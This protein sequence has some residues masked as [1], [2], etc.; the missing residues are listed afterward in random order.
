ME[1][2]LGIVS[3][4]MKMLCV[5]IA[6]IT[7]LIVIF[8]ESLVIR[9][10]IVKEWRGMGISKALGMTSGQLIAEIMMSNAPTIIVGMLIGTAVSRVAGEKLTVLI[11]S[12]FGISHVDFDISFIWMIVTAVGILLVAL[13][14]S[15]LS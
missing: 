7:I 3:D 6:I 2:T 8:V 13:I 11:F 12:F 1:G 15:G 4:S 10:K 9:A 14:A 5:V